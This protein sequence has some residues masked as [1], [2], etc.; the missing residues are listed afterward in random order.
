MTVA[1]VPAF[2]LDADL[3]MTVG[4]RTLA[5]PGPD[6]AVVRV[7]WAGICGSDLHVMRSGAWVADWPATLGHEL[8]GRVQSAPAGSDLAPGTRVVADSRIACGECA[9]CAV[10]PDTCPDIQ[11][12]GEARPGGF[13]THCVLPVSMLHRVPEHLRGSTAVLAEPLAVVLHGLARLDRDPR[14]VAIL[15]H[16]PI[17]ALTHIELRR[18]FPAAEV[19]V[20]EPTAL[21]A[22][23]A[24]AEG[25]RTVSLATDLT[26]RG[27]DTVIDAAGYRGSLTDAVALAGA[28][29]QLLLLAISDAP[30]ELRPIDVVER[31][32]RIVGSN[33]F[34]GELDAA[35]ELLA[36][37]PWRYDPI[38]TE[39]VELAE[40][41]A[42]AARQLDRP[43]AIKVLVRL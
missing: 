2:L 21:R 28:G 41:P 18:R 6:E 40:L 30:V 24:A 25:A 16:G 26:A 11:F 34:Q 5:E 9:A 3:R 7:E 13:A 12:V 27:Y 31:R 35:I 42:V 15:G 8:F 20:A 38:V 10:D 17:G 29:A 33:A 23:L 39:A 19:D 4:R 22:L 1:D 43:D 32:L 37:E 36:A 14:R